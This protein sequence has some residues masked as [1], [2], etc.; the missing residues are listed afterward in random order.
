MIVFKGIPY[1]KL[2]SRL[3]KHPMVLKG[4][5]FVA[6]QTKAQVDSEIFKTCLD[7]IWFI[8]YIFHSISNSI[9]HMDSATS[10]N[11]RNIK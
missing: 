10:P 2:E 6:C 9:L 8:T 7:K 1:S 3:N 11:R 4:K 5:I